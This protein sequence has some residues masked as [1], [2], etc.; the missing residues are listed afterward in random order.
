VASAPANP[1]RERRGASQIH[2]VAHVP[3]SP[4][5]APIIAALLLFAFALYQ[6]LA[7]DNARD[8]FI[9]RL[10]AE[11]AARGENPYDIPK[12]RQHVAAHFPGDDAKEFV[13]NCGYF[14]PP[15]AVLVYLPF[16]ALPWAAAKVAWAVAVGLA[17]YCVARLPGLLRT[18]D[19]PAPGML[20]ASVVPF[21]LLLNPLTLSVVV[22]G[23][24]TLL[25]LGCVA[26][27]LWC[28]DRGRPYLAAVLWAVPFV[29]PHLALPLIPLA[30]FLGGWRPAALLVALV[31][32]LNLAGATVAGGSPL[33]LS[34][35]FD[36]LPSAREAV[37]Y[38]RVT[39][40]A[41]TSWNRLLLAAGGPQVEL[42]AVTTVAGY[43]VW[44]GLVVGRIA[45]T[46]EHPS[47]A[48]A[49]VAV[50]VGAVL[51]SQVLVYEL[52]LLAV[53]VP[54]VRDL[55]AGGWR[56]RGWLAVVLLA[57]QLMPGKPMEALRL[58]S[59]HPLGVALLAV[60]VLA[61]PLNPAPAKRG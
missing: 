60:L 26:A 43:L 20:A 8:F 22:V 11:L 38:N 55:F 52:L 48:W 58:E 9:Y 18:P 31:A 45:V 36:F 17:G 15:L 34:D 51:C 3:G 12:V 44:F 42:T 28:F 27:G 39:N 61:G 30:Y 19:S 4:G 49:V 1:E 37:A 50:A 16:A 13:E 53:A 57:V 21:L 7:T 2:P 33:F 5:I 10:G 6:A 25:S 35:Y 54:W 56:V 47:A 59:Y 29:K 46:G 24:V 14:L 32:A 41:I 40:P 23:Q